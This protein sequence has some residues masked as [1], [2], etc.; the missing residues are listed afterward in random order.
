M[1][2]YCIVSLLH[3]AIPLD[4]IFSS[5]SAPRELRRS[6]SIV[7]PYQSYQSYIVHRRRCNIG[8]SFLWTLN[9]L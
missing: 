8:R 6:S 3:R 7:V 4:V 2:E 5:A 9:E 1:S